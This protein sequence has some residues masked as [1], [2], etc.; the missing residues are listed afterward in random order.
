MQQ[1]M[2]IT[3][4][5]DIYRALVRAVAPRQRS[6]FIEEAIR[7][8]VDMNDLEKDYAALA[9]DERGNAEAREWMEAFVGDVAHEAW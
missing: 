6:K 5:R 4:D 3:L 1:R 2:T 7:P 8:L 9:A